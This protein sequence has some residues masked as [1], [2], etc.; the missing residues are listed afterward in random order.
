MQQ[1]TGPD[2]Q[3]SF[4]PL[5]CLVSTYGSHSNMTAAG[6]TALAIPLVSPGL[7]AQGTESVV[8]LEPVS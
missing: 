6:L 8:E 7:G 3:G 1:S 4:H 2:G 5:H